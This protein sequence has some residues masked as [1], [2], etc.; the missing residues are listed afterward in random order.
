MTDTSLIA[1]SVDVLASAAVD[2]RD[3]IGGITQ[4]QDSPAGGS[5]PDF[6]AWPKLPSPLEESLENWR[7]RYPQAAPK[8]LG[9][10]LFAHV[11]PDTGKAPHRAREILRAGL[12]DGRPDDR[13]LIGITT[14]DPRMRALP[15]EVLHNGT[16]YLLAANQV[17][18]RHVNDGFKIEPKTHDFRRFLAI[19]A[20][21]IGYPPFK[22]DE[23]AAKI[24]EV[25][26]EDPLSLRVLAHASR[27]EVLD[28]LKAPGGEPFDAIFIVAHGLGPS[29]SSDGHVVLEGAG[30]LPEKLAAGALAHALVPHKGC[31]VVLCSCSS[32]AVNDDNPIAGMAQRLITA[33]RAGAVI[34]MQR[35][36]RISIGLDFIVSVCRSLRTQWSDIFEAFNAAT[37]AA[38]YGKPEH[39]IP[40]LYTRLPRRLASGVG[41]LT[42][43]ART[44][45]DELLRLQ[46]LL[47]AD[48]KSTFA[49]SV[50]QFRFGWPI[51]EWANLPPSEAASVS[52]EERRP[53][54]YPGPTASVH[55]IGAIQ[56]FI[57]LVGRF[58]AR[59][60]LSRRIE[61]VP[62]WEAGP[63]LDRQ[64]YTHFV[65]IGSRSH[66]LSRQKLQNYSEDFDF[67]FSDNSWR[68]IDK[69]GQTYEV[70]APDKISE[71]VAGTKDYAIIEKIIDTINGRV[72]FVIAGMWDTSTHAAGRYLT[73][74][75]D[76]IFAKFGNGGFQYILETV[77]GSPD[78]KRVVLARSP[79]IN[80]R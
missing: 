64:E 28:C 41:L 70:H 27:D 22:H 32:A 78:V 47:T 35:P 30:R 17:V 52:K 13:V 29:G 24:Q 79:R 16:E 44:P 59:G 12:V 37:A 26:E 34:G 7:T 23:F 54:R 3:S 42:S 4:V 65:L 73:D 57:A 51:A 8:L 56:H 55:D 18:F 39:G 20:E 11:F 53:Y 80:G 36:I 63:L 74:H 43:F 60:Q 50:G 21:P 76:E 15:F 45:D 1:I 2:A 46:S 31:L 61:I 69:R 75:R 77:Q 10:Q 72:L 9:E 38:T 49:F 6:F 67:E 5:T 48:Q 62:D 14:A 71:P 68:L 33:G 25:F 58:L 19:L 40:C 66:S